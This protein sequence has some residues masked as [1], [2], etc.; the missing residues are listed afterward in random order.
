MN[1]DKFLLGTEHS[2]TILHSESTDPDRSGSCLSSHS[3]GIA[4]GIEICIT[5]PTEYV[6]TQ[7][8]LDER[9][10]PPRYRGIGRSSDVS[11]YVTGGADEGRCASLALGN[12]LMH[13]LC[14]R[15]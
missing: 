7:L 1:A 11:L 12:S 4:G 9:A 15:R 5:F 13:P 3:G 8:Q 14:V 10:N 2:G 6:K